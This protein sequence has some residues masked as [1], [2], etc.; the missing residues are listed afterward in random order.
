MNNRPPPQTIASVAASS[1]S[2][3]RGVSRAG[4]SSRARRSE[5]AASA[6]IMN[7]GTLRRL[8]VAS[9]KTSPAATMSVSRRIDERLSRR[10]NVRPA[11]TAATAKNGRSSGFESDGGCHSMTP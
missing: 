1:T 7:G 11:R 8:R 4:A 10:R 3:R 5:I 6:T 9:T 2:I